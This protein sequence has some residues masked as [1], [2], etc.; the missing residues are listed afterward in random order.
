MLKCARASHKRKCM[1]MKRYKPRCDVKVVLSLSASSILICQKLLLA[2]SVEKTV[3]LLSESM[4]PSIRCMEYE[5]RFLTA[6]RFRYSTL[7]FR[8][9]SFLGTNNIGAA[10]LVCPVFMMFFVIVLLT[11]TFFNF[12]VLVLVR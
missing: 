10:H 2:S 5:S 3:A 7:N 12:R 8:V 4:Y 6:F 9:F 11:L 1:R